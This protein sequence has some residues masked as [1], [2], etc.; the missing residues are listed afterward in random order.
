[1]TTLDHSLPEP[2]P[3]ALAHSARLSAH[4]RAEMAAN[5]GALPFDRFMELALYAPGLGYYSAGARKFGVEGDFVTAPEL[6]P[7]FSRCLARQCRQILAETGGGVLELGA[8]SGV[9]AADI[10]SELERL[11]SLPTRY[12]MLEVSADL[13]ERQRRT[14]AERAP[15]LLERV[16]W[17]DGLPPGDWRGVIVANEVVDAMPVARFRITAQGPRPL[18]VSWRQDRF[19]W[20]V[21]DA[22]PATTATVAAL[23]AELGLEFPV[24]YQAEFNP[25]LPAWI[26]ALAA[27]LQSGVILL[28]DYGHP[29]REYYHPARAGGA[30]RCY[31][32]HRVH[33]DPLRWP[34]LQDITAS[35]DFSALAEAALAAGL[36]VAGYTRQNYFLFGCGLESLAAEVDPADTL[37][38]L[39]LAD[40]IK[41]LTMPG[42]MG[43]LCKALALSKHFTEPLRG[44]GFYDERSRL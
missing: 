23:Q 42:A 30:L 43:D 12:A 21:G 25:R 16:S 24:G 10:L 27:A 19:A 34:G 33:A 13:R 9:M 44:F 1:M 36:N 2:E 26:A 15:A 7:L 4:I 28:L 17:L 38:Y 31:Y 32:R 18:Q 37:A 39:Q 8:G 41:L 5:G 22:D 6:S 40:Q 14:L 29:R 3:A 11:D 20:R 35:V